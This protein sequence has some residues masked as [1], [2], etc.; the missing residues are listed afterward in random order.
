M[1]ARDALKTALAGSQHV[2][3]WY[4]EDLSDADLLVRPVPNANHIAW[5]LGHLVDSEPHLLGGQLPGVSYPPLPA[6]W[7]DQHSKKTASMEPA[8]GFATKAEY[9]R[10]LKQMRDA[11]IAALAKVSDADL[12]RPT[13][14]SMA[15]FAPTI[16]ALVVLTSNHTLM[17]AGQ[18]TV[19]RRKL[20][21][22]V[23]F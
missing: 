4:L 17:H 20:G 9:L 3:N 13:T 12:D 8:K 2:L 23:L 14:G 11:T 10:L 6:G 1:N 19:V 18:F 16:G 22:T 5:Q 15:Q 7:S 21:K